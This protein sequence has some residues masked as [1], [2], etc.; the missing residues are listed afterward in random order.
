SKVK[1]SL[2]YYVPRTLL[3]CIANVLDMMDYTTYTKYEIRKIYE[4]DARE[5]ITP[6]LK[7]KGF[8]FVETDEKEIGGYNLDIYAS[9]PTSRTSYRKKAFGEV[10]IMNRS[11][12][13]AKIEKFVGWLKQMKNVEYNPAKGDFAFFI[14]PPNRITDNSKR[15]LS[16]NNISPYEFPSKNVE[17]L[18][19]HVEKT[20]PGPEVNIED[21]PAGLDTGE[22]IVIKDSRYQLE[23]IKGIA[24]TRANQLREIGITTVKELINCNSSVTAQKIKGVGKIS[25]NKWKQ[26]ARQLLN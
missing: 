19:K 13:V 26:I 24:E 12:M 25:I 20:V 6:K 17:E 10:S 9:A 8:N 2:D 16:D 18:L 5:F 23:D 21:I 11:N 15:I 7:D 1:S 14:C 4:K 22:I 3:R